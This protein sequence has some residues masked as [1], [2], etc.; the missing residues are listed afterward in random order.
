MIR[1]LYE[2][3]LLSQ[4]NRKQGQRPEH[5]TMILSESD[6]L[7]DSG[8]EKLSAFLKWCFALDIKIISI[9]VDVLDVKEE[10]KTRIVSLL[11]DE[12]K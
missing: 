4:I 12:L 7:D 1:A 6:L 11:L 10:A 2:Q 3:Y 8:K 5:I 9:Y